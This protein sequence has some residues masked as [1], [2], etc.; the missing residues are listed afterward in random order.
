MQKEFSHILKV[1]D[2]PLKETKHNIVANADELE[3]LQNLLE[4][5]SVD[6]LSGYVKTIIDKKTNRLDILGNVKA[7]VVLN[8][9]VSLKDFSQNYDIDFSN[10]YDLKAKPEDF[11]GLEFGLEDEIPDVIVGGAIDIAELLIEQIAL[12][13]DEYPRIEGEVFN[14]KS[15]FDPEEKKNPFAVLEQLKKKK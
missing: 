13:I 11:D 5:V 10:F 8:S 9:V 14:F 1:E 2:I 7:T 15:E 4:V 6:S 12:A 3:Y